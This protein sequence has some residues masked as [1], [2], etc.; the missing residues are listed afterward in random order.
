[1]S[2]YWAQRQ[3]LPVLGA[4]L[5]PAANRRSGRALASRT[6]QPTRSNPH[7]TLGRCSNSRVD[8]ALQ[9]SP[10]RAS[11]DPAALH[12]TRG[13]FH[14]CGLQGRCRSSPRLVPRPQRSRMPCPSSGGRLMATPPRLVEEPE[15]SES[16]RLENDNYP[17]MKRTRGARRGESSRWSCSNLS[18]L[19]GAGTRAPRGK[20]TLCVGTAVPPSRRKTAKCCRAHNFSSWANV[21]SLMDPWHSAS[22]DQYG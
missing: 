11:D 4:G 3:M 13:G 2:R 14:R 16:W 5:R 15:R 19:G 12:P 21:E 17:A 22:A 6:C 1:L 20:R 18:E 9:R 10:G 7:L 8:K